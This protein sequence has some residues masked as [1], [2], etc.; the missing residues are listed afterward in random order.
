MSGSNLSSTVQSHCKHCGKEIYKK[1]YNTFCNRSCAASFTN[2]VKT[3]NKKCVKC[4]SEFEVLPHLDF[5]KYCSRECYD[6]TITVSQTD[7][8]VRNAQEKKVCSFCSIEFTRAVTFSKKPR[9][10]KTGKSFCSGSCR[11]KYVHANCNPTQHTNKSLPQQILYALLQKEFP[12]EPILY[13]DRTTLKSSIE[14]DIVFPRLKVAIEVNGPIHYLPI[15]GEEKF[16]TVVNRDSVK[17]AEAYSM[18]YNLIVIDVSKLQKRNYEKVMTGHLTDT[19]KPIILGLLKK[20]MGHD[21]TSPSS[22]S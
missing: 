21:G 3:I 12:N 1:R 5:K 22:I 13:N 9:N 16:Q 15:F 18:G 11:S 19:I 2:K 10:P 7:S 17:M 8:Y 6:K 20:D 4:G 14:L